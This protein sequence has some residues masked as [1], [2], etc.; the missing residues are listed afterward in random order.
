[1]HLLGICKLATM[2]APEDCMLANVWDYTFVIGQ[3]PSW[4]NFTTDEN[5]VIYIISNLWGATYQ[6]DVR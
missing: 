5:C 4:W 3:M 1:M 2:G 6:E